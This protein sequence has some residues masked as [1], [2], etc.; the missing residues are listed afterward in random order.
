MKR[1]TLLLVL[2]LLTACGPG[3]TNGPAGAGGPP[4]GMPPAEVTERVPC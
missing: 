1:T 4:G 2:P 3:D